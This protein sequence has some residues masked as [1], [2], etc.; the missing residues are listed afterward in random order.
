MFRFFNVGPIIWPLPFENQIFLE[1]HSKT[2]QKF[3]VL[4]FRCFRYLDVHYSD[5]HW[6]IIQPF[7]TSMCVELRNT[8]S[9]SFLQI[10][11]AI[12]IKKIYE[13]ILI[14][15]YSRHS[16]IGPLVT[17]NIHLPDFL[18]VTQ[19]TIWLPDK[20]SSNWMAVRHLWTIRPFSYRTFR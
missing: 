1:G 13:P 8:A 18:S 7:T 11:Q 4:R 5:P 9:T 15:D 19:V 6:I 14:P 10:A 20:K 2:D 17:R 12:N 16:I 3:P